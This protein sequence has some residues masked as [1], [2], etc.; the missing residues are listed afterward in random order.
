M[1]LFGLWV[2]WL[3]NSKPCPVMHHQEPVRYDILGACGVHEVQK[4]LV[5]MHQE[6]FTA[7]PEKP[8]HVHNNDGDFPDLKA[9]QAAPSHGLIRGK[10]S[11][12]FVPP[13]GQ[14]P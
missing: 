3:C 11:G 4:D 8:V 9:P 12:H 5:Q 1:G 7:G 2:M 6:F 13:F 14:Q 10:Q